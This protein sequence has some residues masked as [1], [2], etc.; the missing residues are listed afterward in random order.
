[1]LS[2]VL[3]TASFRNAEIGSKGRATH[4][5]RA[6]RIGGTGDEARASVLR[7]AEALGETSVLE[8][9]SN[10]PALEWSGERPK[11]PGRLAE[12]RPCVIRPS[13]FLSDSPL[14]IFAPA[15]NS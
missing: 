11:Q 7:E 5:V 9:D 12:I 8:I 10:H 2:R 1:M 4:G 13:R 3:A 14:P 15:F 6:L